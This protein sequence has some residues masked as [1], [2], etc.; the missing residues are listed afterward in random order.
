M[1]FA[2]SIPD[3][4]IAPP[5]RFPPGIDAAD[6]LID[7]FH[8]GWLAPNRPG[9][10]P[11]DPCGQCGG[12]YRRWATYTNPI[13]FGVTYLPHLFQRYR[14][15][16]GEPCWSFCDLHLDMAHLARR[17]AVPGEHRDIV[18]GPRDV[19]KSLCWIRDALWALAHGHRDFLLVFSYTR[20]QVLIQLGELRAAM[21]SPLLLADFPGLAPRRGRGARNTLNYV[22]VS[23]ASIMGRGL[24]ESVLGARGLGGKRPTLIVWDDG[25]PE[26]GKHD[27]RIKA[28]LLVKLT[29]TIL[30]MNAD[31]AVL[32]VGTPTMPGS[33]IHDGV[34]AAQ[35]RPGVLPD[36]GQ[37][38]ARHRFRPH[39]WPAILNEGTRDMRSLWREKWPLPRLLR[40]RAA[41]PDGFAMNMQCD[42]SAQTA[43]RLWTPESYRYA[44]G[45]PIESRVLSID[46]AV[47]RKTT[48]DMSALVVA[49]Q[50][51]DVRRCVAEH[52]QAG[53]WTG[54]ELRELVWHYA[55]QYPRT[56]HTVVI[57]TNNGGD[58]CIEV[59]EPFPPGVEVIGYRNSGGKRQRI[60]AL[61]K[62]YRR[63]AVLH[64]TRLPELEDQQCDWSPSLL[65]SPGVD[66]LIDAASGAVRWCLF[67]WPGDVEPKL[68]PVRS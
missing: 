41:D 1:R 49:G 14:G 6:Y 11:A 47:T 65:N 7:C 16:D 66:D 51:A 3:D 19:A 64:A 55:E 8:G 30:P 29:S 33:L 24:G 15:P 42:P 52:A 35:H 13:A 23:G 4:E 46:G 5:P 25:E 53:R 43:Q 62:Q 56:L 12:C 17:W 34:R 2:A 22:T 59:L 27:A 37:W 36:R 67:G 63:G 54:R 68:R 61:A 57:E 58:L 9:C 10:T 45:L 20:E 26:D 60:E 21:D 32:M 28:A 40:D 31:A 39:Y 38:I 44:H 18:I 48:S 50:P